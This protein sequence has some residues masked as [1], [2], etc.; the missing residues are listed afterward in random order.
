MDADKVYKDLK[1]EANALIGR[2]R[3][4]ESRIEAVKTLRSNN[5]DRR[6]RI[7][8]LEAQLAELMDDV[9]DNK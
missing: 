7:E 1:D 4:L 3:E 6:V 2:E 5:R 9:L 8:K